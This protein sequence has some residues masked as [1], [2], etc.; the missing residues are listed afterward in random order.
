MFARHGCGGGDG[1]G[2]I[3]RLIKTTEAPSP[4]NRHCVFCT[5]H[6]AGN[7]GCP[8]QPPIFARV[9]FH[10]HANALSSQGFVGTEGFAQLQKSHRRHPSDDEGAVMMVVAWS[11]AFHRPTGMKLKQGP[12]RSCVRAAA[13]KR[14]HRD[15]ERCRSDNQTTNKRPSIW[16]RDWVPKKTK[17]NSN[18]RNSGRLHLRRTTMT[19]DSSTRRLSKQRRLP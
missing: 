1:D 9:P 6:S 16:S 15:V 13:A 11:G 17:R 2:G 8:F 12:D 7:H 18:V 5:L 19:E 3:A 14:E 4:E 10:Y